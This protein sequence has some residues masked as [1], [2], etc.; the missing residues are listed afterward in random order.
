M[1][2]QIQLE[3]CIHGELCEYSHIP[4]CCEAICAANN[5][6]S[7]QEERMPIAA[8]IPPTRMAMLE[9]LMKKENERK[10]EKGKGCLLLSLDLVVK[11]IW[12]SSTSKFK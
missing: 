12:R 10:E 8:R 9:E 3:L 1:G 2:L 4:I 11:R 6:N 5:L 7:P